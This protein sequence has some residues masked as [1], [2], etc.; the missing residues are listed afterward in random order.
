MKD[1]G[2]SK[3][4]LKRHI[5][6]L[7]LEHVFVLSEFDTPGISR[8]SPDE[9]SAALVFP[10]FLSSRF[11]SSFSFKWAL[12]GTSVTFPHTGVDRLRST[13]KK[14]LSC[15]PVAHFIPCRFKCVFGAAPHTQ[16][17]AS[18]HNRGSRNSCF[19]SEMHTVWMNYS[20]V[21]SPLSQLLF[22]LSQQDVLGCCVNHGQFCRLGLFNAW[23][24]SVF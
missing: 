24:Q 17:N 4:K 8:F 10:S 19:V 15:F 23:I 16:A 22:D 13:A 11:C 14:Q 20:F 5:F 9:R 21:R 3:F 7:L 12:W 6:A 1:I 2:V 18:A